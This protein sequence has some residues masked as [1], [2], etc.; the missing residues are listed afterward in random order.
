MMEATLLAR[1]SPELRN[2]IW[3][4]V[5]T[6]DYA[7]TL[8]TGGTQHALTKTCRQIRRETLA[9]YYTAA[10]LNAHLDDGPATPLAKWLQNI[11]REHCLLVRE[12]NIW[13]R[14]RLFVTPMVSQLTTVR[15]CTC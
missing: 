4:A 14:D 3:E 15:T 2:A 6:S 9:M 5:F 8:Q 13:V 1:L 10:R 11:G 12:L 7:I